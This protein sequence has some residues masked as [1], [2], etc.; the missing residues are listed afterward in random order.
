MTA[1]TQNADREGGPE[2]FGA[3]YFSGAQ[4]RF[5][6]PD[7]IAGSAA[8]PQSLNMY[9]YVW[10]NPLRHTDPTGMVVSWE[11]SDVGCRKGEIKCRTNLQRKYETNITN[12]LRS[13]NAKNRTRGEALQATYQKLEDAEEVFHVVRTAGDGSGELS[14]LGKPGHLY[15]QLRGDGSSYGHMPDV[16]KLAHEFKHGEQFLEGLIGFQQLP[17]G[18]W[19]GYRDD[20]VDEANAFMAGFAAQPVGNDQSRFLQELQRAADL[21]G[22]SGVI[23]RLGQPSSPYAGR[24][25]TQLPIVFPSG[26]IPPSIYAVPRAR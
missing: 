22:L 11:D 20:L 7:P 26:K 14:Y 1:F 24:S 9:A 2:Y 16:Q 13:K 23:K 25:D 19:T 6:S 3:R 17:S 15:V 21:N 5:T 12:L 8:N 4:G 18:Q 10:N